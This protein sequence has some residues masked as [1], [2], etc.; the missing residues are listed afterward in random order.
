M[1]KPW[2]ATTVFV[3]NAPNQTHIVTGKWGEPSIAV[4]DTPEHAAFIVRA[5]NAHE[6]LVAGLTAIRARI[7]GEWDNPAL[8]AFGELYVDS[9]IDILRIADEALGAVQS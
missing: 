2:K 7:N 3:N 5:C 9:D 6:A 1:E 8:E 4:V